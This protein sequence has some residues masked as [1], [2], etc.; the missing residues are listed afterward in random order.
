MTK[1]PIGVGEWEGVGVCLLGQERDQQS[2]KN[3][4]RLF[5]GSFWR[6]TLPVVPNSFI[7]GILRRSTLI[8]PRDVTAMMPRA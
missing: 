6:V 4:P 7:S 8:E 2:N 1:F 5:V 3:Y